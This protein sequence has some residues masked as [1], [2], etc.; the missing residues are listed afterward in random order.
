MLRE[1]LAASES[2]ALL[3]AA[4]ESSLG[5]R[6]RAARI[7]RE[8]EAALAE[9]S[10]QGAWRL[11]LESIARELDATFARDAPACRAGR[12]ARPASSKR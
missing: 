8:G 2:K 5:P 1:L 11:R 12:A 7:A 4:A 3:A 10:R 9:P 6:A